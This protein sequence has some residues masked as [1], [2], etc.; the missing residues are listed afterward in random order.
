MPTYNAR[1]VSKMLSSK[2]QCKIRENKHHMCYEV[3]EGEMLVAQ[4]HMSRNGEDIN[5]Y[6]QKRMSSQL[7][8]PKKLFED[9]VDC[10]AS[11]HDYIEHM[12]ETTNPD[13]S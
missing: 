11:R 6:L 3:H 10:P 1:E 4:T 8:I 13:S 7:G 12:I 9:L 5:A 2:L